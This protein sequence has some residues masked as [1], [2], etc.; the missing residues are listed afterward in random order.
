MLNEYFQTTDY[1]NLPLTQQQGLGIN[2]D[3][4]FVKGC[5][6][7]KKYYDQPDKNVLQKLRVRYYQIAQFDDNGK[8]AIRSFLFEGESSKGACFFTYKM[9]EIKDY[10]LDKDKLDKFLQTIRMKKL[11][12]KDPNFKIMY[13]FHP[14]YNFIYTNPPTGND[15]NECVSDLLN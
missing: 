15:I 1:T 14:T 6:F 5:D 13:K 2:K 9:I 11:N 8:V 4:E 7:Y 10:Q 12:N 3:I